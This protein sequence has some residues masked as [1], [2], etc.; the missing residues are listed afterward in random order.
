[1]IGTIKLQRIINEIDDILNRMH[2]P[3]AENRYSVENKVLS[4]IFDKGTHI[5]VFISDIYDASS[6]KR[7]DY[8]DGIII[9]RI[10]IKLGKD[11][12]CTFSLKI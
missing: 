8:F 12:S 4:T 11:N 6:I 3:H 10:R 2:N 9:Q 5:N 7:D 1:M